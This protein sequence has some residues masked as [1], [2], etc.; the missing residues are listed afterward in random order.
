MADA[1]DAITTD[2]PYR[3]RREKAEALKEIQNHAGTQFDPEMAGKFIAFLRRTSS[4]L[5]DLESQDLKDDH[6]LSQEQIQFLKKKYSSK[7]LCLNR[8][9]VKADQHQSDLSQPAGA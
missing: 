1:Y 7:I 9:R 8:R 4:D 6:L 5:G 2:R 3:S